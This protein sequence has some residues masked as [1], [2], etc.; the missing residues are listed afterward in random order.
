MIWMLE[1]PQK[2]D[3]TK[4]RTNECFERYGKVVIVSYF[5]HIDM[6]TIQIVKAIRPTFV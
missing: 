5:I 2:L 3:D 1:V 6:C 4:Y